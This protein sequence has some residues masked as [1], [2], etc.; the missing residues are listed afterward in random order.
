MTEARQ[1]ER[2]K[3]LN[4]ILDVVPNMKIVIGELKKKGG[5]KVHYHLVAL[6]IY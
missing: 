3:F 4:D 5:R 2:K 1:R 6:L